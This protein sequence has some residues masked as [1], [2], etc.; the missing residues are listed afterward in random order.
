MTNDISIAFLAIL[1]LTDQYNKWVIE[2]DVDQIKYTKS[3]FN[4]AGIALNKAQCH[5]T[6]SHQIK[7]CDTIITNTT[8]LHKL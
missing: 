5:V 6:K 1:Y 3:S 4:S 2:T 8:G 7:C